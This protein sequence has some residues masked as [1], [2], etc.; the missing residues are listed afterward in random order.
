MK[1]L[2]PCNLMPLFITLALLSVAATKSQAQR[3][4]LELGEVKATATPT[5]ISLVG[6]VT[7]ISPSS[8][9]GVS[10]FCDFHN[11]AGKVLQT[12]QGHLE[13]DPL[14]KGKTSEFKISGK[15]SPDI[16]GYNLRF[17]RLFGG[18]LVVTNKKK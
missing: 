17:V 3:P 2:F 5:T 16:K 14:P 15:S 8:L 10:V 4:S 11:G 9:S 13:T 18:P 12:S 6:E 7:N 1:R